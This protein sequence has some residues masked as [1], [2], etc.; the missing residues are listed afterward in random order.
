MRKKNG[1][2]TNS[3]EEFY[4]FCVSRNQ[5]LGFPTSLILQLFRSTEQECHESSMSRRALLTNLSHLWMSWR[6]VTRVQTNNNQFD[7]GME[8]WEGHRNWRE[9]KRQSKWARKR[10][11]SKLSSFVWI[12]RTD[13]TVERMDENSRPRE[14]EHRCTV[15]ILFD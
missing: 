6:Q 5:P 4:Q 7:R 14:G 10:G 11:R 15:G 9:N 13:A 12:S 8:V 1:K 3:N 2:V